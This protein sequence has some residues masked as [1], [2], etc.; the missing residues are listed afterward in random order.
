[1]IEVNNL[2]KS[3]KLSKK[4]MQKAKTKEKIVVAV[5]GVSFIAKPGEIFG[6]LGPNGAGKTT[7]LRCVSTLLKPTG[8]DI[9]VMG[10]DV[11]SESEKVRKHI[12]FLTNE[13][14]LDKHFTPD[15]TV[16][17]FAQL[18]NLDRESINKR[19]E[20]LFDYF[21]ITNYRQKKIGELSTGMMQKLSI[22]VSLIHDPDVIIFDEPTNGLDIVTAKKVTEYLKVLRNQGK[23]VVISTHIMDLAEKLCDRIA[24]MLDGEVKIHGTLQHIL[25]ETGEKDLE[26]AFFK[27][28]KDL[29]PEM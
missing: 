8:G 22:V 4:K 12:A 28:Y 27:V 16:D 15:Y 13:L 24:I 5:N 21:G 6:L 20:E 29:Y 10:K 7:T 14:K 9:R 19:K 3:Y 2:V 25:E 23:V 17:F 18:Y 11:E 26:E 1:M